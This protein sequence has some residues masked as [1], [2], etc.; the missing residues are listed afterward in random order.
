MPSTQGVSFQMLVNLTIRS[1]FP[2][3]SQIIAKR[4][5]LL[6]AS[7]LLIKRPWLGSNHITA[8]QPGTN[9]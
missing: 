1:A 2:A 5:A 4:P 7:T 9:S 3:A 6:I 8:D